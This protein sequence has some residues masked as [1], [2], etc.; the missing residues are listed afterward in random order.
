MVRLV[1]VRVGFLPSEAVRDA[2]VA[3]HGSDVIGN[4]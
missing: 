1:W 4:R 3:A 2:V